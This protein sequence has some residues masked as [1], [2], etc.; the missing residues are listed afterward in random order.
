MN[1]KWQIPK[2]E[3]PDP[4]VNVCLVLLETAKL[5]SRVIVCY[6]NSHQQCMRVLVRMHPY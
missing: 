1:S 4:M 6:L 3:L 2:V 5:F